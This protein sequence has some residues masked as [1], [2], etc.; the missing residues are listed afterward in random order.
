MCPVIPLFILIAIDTRDGTYRAL[1]RKLSFPLS[2]C[3]EKVLWLVRAFREEGGADNNSTLKG[4]YMFCNHCGRFVHET[5]AL[6]INGLPWCDIQCF[7]GE[8]QSATQLELF[9]EADLMSKNHNTIFSEW[10]RTARK[11]V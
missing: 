7:Q 11:E 4:E 2:S 3:D 1:W 9:E 6:I 5:L 8:T 10:E